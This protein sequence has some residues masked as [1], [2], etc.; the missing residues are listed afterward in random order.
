LWGR[1][2]ACMSLWVL[3]CTAISS[4][5]R[6]RAAGMAPAS[7]GRACATRAGQGTCVLRVR[8]GGTAL[9]ATRRACTCW[10]P[11]LRVRAEG[12]ATTGRRG[13]AGAAVW[14]T[15]SR[16]PG[17]R[18]VLMDGQVRRALWRAT[19]E[20]VARAVWPRTRRW[21]SVAA[22]RD[23]CWGILAADAMRVLVGTTVRCALHARAR[24]AA[25][26]M[27]GPPGLARAVVTLGTWVLAVRLRA[28]WR[29][30]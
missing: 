23:S 9:R 15:G 7:V 19:A 18:R 29:G 6:R 16:A 3:W 24:T 14:G 10:S 12:R 13:P 1:C 11:G 26:A 17:V 4:V 2:L 30:T 21:W 8:L 20:W 28:R 25:C 5:R 22:R 27:L